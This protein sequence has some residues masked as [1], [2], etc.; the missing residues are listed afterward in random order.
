MEYT[1]K[2]LA[3]LAGVTPRTLRW[4]DREG[5]LCPAG[6]TE[7]GYRLYGPAEVDR[8]QQILFYR[9]LGLE[10]AAIRAI[11]DDPQ[12]D[13]QAAL[14]SHLAELEGRRA[15]LDGLILTVKKTLKGADTMSDQEKFEGFKARLIRE[16]EETYGAEARRNYGDGAVDASH[17]KL[18]EMTE[19][20][21]QAMTALEQD[22]RDKLEQAVRAGADP[23]GE[24]GR[25]IAAAHRDWLAY[26]WAAGQYSPEAHRALAAMYTADPRF[27]GY[28]D[29]T[30]PGCAAFLQAAVEAHIQT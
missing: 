18:A 1:V 12:F 9:E 23:A 3:E 4:Y 15:R 27:T 22:I 11:L 13:R 16:N 20:E 6:R 19:E 24:V 5:L 25:D 30:V 10:L 2:A 29:R 17:A 26:T 28:Y 7:A 14:Q 8:L 21:Y